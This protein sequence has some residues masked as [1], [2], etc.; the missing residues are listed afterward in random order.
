MDLSSGIMEPLD[1][2]TNIS[3]VVLE[4]Y[5]HT[6]YNNNCLIFIKSAE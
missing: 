5:I 1:C 2:P 4:K 3:R 6:S